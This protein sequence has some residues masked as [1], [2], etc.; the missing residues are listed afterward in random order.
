MGGWGVKG[1]QTVNPA[2]ISQNKI[3]SRERARERRQ[4]GQEVDEGPG[5]IA[6]L[7]VS[8]LRWGG[9]TLQTDISMRMRVCVCKYIYIYIYYI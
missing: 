1:A 3:R 9:G 6:L 8:I 7:P 5:K 2:R 4:I